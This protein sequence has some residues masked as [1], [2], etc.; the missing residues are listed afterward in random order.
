MT[1][2]EKIRSMTEEELAAFIYR[3]RKNWTCR[4]L[5]EK[6]ECR[7]NCKECYREWVKKEAKESET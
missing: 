6:E 2:A 3:L 7:A 5:I 1:N 4:P